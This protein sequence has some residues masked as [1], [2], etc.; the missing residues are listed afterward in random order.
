[1]GEQEVLAAKR[2]K[3][4]RLGAGLTAEALARESARAGVETLDRGTIAK[5]ES[6]NRQ[7]RAGEVDTV[8]R[9]FGVTSTDLLNPGP[10]V[11]VSYARPDDD[12]GREVSAWLAERGFWVPPP[13]EAVNDAA[14]A[15]VM[16]LSP[17]FI[18]SPACMAEFE[19]AAQPHQ[20]VQPASQVYVLQVADTAGR[21]AS[22]FSGYPAIDLV[23]VSGRKRE[24]ALSK[25]GSMILRASAGADAP[26]TSDRAG[27]GRQAFLDRADELDR[28][29]NGLNRT[30]G[31]HFWL[32]MSPPGL[33][34]TEFL[35]RLEAS[36][37]EQPGQRWIT[38]TVDLRAEAAE[39]RGDALTL[40]GGLVGVTLS[41]KPD[42]DLRTAAKKIIRA[43]RPHLY[44][45][46]SAELLESATVAALR[47]HLSQIHQR[48]QESG[49]PDADVS[50]VAAS[51]RDD[52]WRGVA[53]PRMSIMP[54]TEFDTAAVQEA[55]SDLA[56]RMRRQ[57]SPQELRD[58]AARVQ[59][60]TEGVPALVRAVLEWIQAEEGLEIERLD[61]PDVVGQILGPFIRDRLLAR[62]SLLPGDTSQ[63][64]TS[65]KRLR[66]IQDAIKWLVPYRFFTLSYLRH[67]SGDRSFTAAMDDAG[68][69]FDDLW[70]AIGDCSLLTRPLDEPW[71][72]FHPAVRRLLFRHF[73]AETEQADTHREACD[74]TE[75]WLANQTGPEQVIGLLECIWHEAA[76]LRLTN[77]AKMG[78][79]LTESVRKRVQTIVGTPVYTTDELKAYA[80]E[81]MR[82]DDELRGEV[83]GID[84]LFDTLVHTI[85]GSAA[86]G[87]ML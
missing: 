61:Q 3:M 43:G 74:L 79:V 58:D 31:Q 16:L 35:R 34:K 41:G 68:W 39:F 45:L 62:D 60:A 85:E 38:R 51:R 83:A 4:L 52:G 5:I 59:R 18:D 84:G 25:L 50:L 13:E 81:R 44:Q 14:H 46:D 2:M 32:V 78:G 57:K 1:M 75:G 29:R 48:V 87:S 27:D 11:F 66:V 23:A 72:E 64:E 53:H 26:V 33:G 9:V 80:A 73:Y 12:V 82:N 19:L 54:L 63:S 17:A 20:L 24:E 76:A 15:F 55:V 8:A 69:R 86:R 10:A 7:I 65:E 30:A 21:P 37:R 77:A 22:A 49:D 70:Q 42:D 67:L 6:D 56:S 28:V 36:V 71:Q 40:V 47:R